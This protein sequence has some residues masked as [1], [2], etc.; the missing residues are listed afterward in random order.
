[1]PDSV[2]V[3]ITERNGQELGYQEEVELTGSNIPF[4][5][6]GFSSDNLQSAVEESASTGG[7][8]RYV[9]ACGYESTVQDGRYLEFHR[10]N[11]S[12]LDPYVAPEPVLVISL[13]F[14]IPAVKTTVTLSI[15]KNGVLADTVVLSSAKKASKVFTPPISLATDDEISIAKTAGDNP[16]SITAFPHFKVPFS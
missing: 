5:A 3:S 12:N 15:Y 9:V 13:S 10:G 14:T 1:M 6:T 8:S 2:K 4:S 16:A 7:Q 11:P